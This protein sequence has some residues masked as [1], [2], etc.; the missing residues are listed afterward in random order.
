[1][2]RRYTPSSVDTQSLDNIELIENYRP[3]ALI[4]AEPADEEIQIC[5]SATAIS[6]SCMASP[7]SQT[8][9]L[10]SPALR[11]DV[12][13]AYT[14]STWYN[15]NSVSTVSLVPSIQKRSEIDVRSLGSIEVEYSNLDPG[16]KD[17]AKILI[18]LGSNKIP[19]LIFDHIQRLSWD[20][21][22][23]IT[24][25]FEPDYACLRNLDIIKSIL[26][27]LEDSRLITLSGGIPIFITVDPRLQACIESN[28]EVMEKGKIMATRFIAH[29]YPR[30]RAADPL[31]TTLTKAWPHEDDTKK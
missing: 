4:S 29:A 31:S 19:L 20:E 14:F 30:L 9:T 22:G 13:P 25:E 23:E 15:L 2:S 11:F 21:A 8:H 28:A 6:G 10:S 16:S 27:R 18:T 12:L 5:E 1:M 7:S 26:K 17:F 3:T 24:S